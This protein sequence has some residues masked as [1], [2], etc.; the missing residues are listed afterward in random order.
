MDWARHRR[1]VVVELLGDQLAHG[2]SDGGNIKV[3]TPPQLTHSVIG[4]PDQPCHI[5][6]SDQR[7]GVSSD[8]RRSRIQEDG[9]LWSSPLGA[10]LHP[11]T[12]Y[13]RMAMV[14]YTHPER[15]LEL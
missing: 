9:Y 1:E 13:H 15:K 12:Q 8:W 4:H 14:C 2:V 5:R 7:L 10:G 3:D 11:R 6:Q